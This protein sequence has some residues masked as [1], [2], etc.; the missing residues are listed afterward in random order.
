[1]SLT[2]V[3]DTDNFSIWKTKTNMISSNLG[4]VA[5]LDAEILA[6]IAPDSDLVEAINYIMSSVSRKILIKAIAMS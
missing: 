6:G 2:Q 4:D 5:Q 3:L 1:M